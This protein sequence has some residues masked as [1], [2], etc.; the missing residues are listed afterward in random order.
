MLSCVELRFQ[1][2]QSMPPARAVAKVAKHLGVHRKL[3]FQARFGHPRNNSFVKHVSF[4]IAF[5]HN[6]CLRQIEK[7]VAT[8]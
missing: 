8:I 6:V 5:Q 1:S 3:W 7:P 2:P 4:C